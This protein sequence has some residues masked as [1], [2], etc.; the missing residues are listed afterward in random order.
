MKLKFTALEYTAEDA[1]SPAQYSFDGDVTSGWE[2]RRNSQTYLTLGPGYEPMK[3]RLCGVCA[4]DL[5]RRFLPFPL[6]QITGHEVVAVRLHNG[7]KCVVEINDTPHYRGDTV[8]DPFSNAGLPTHTP[9][10]MVL[11]IDRLPGG[12]GPYLLAPKHAVL[13][14]DGIH[15]TAA[16]LVEPFAAALQAVISAPPRHN[17][18]VAILGP[19]RL[20]ALLVAALKA[21]KRAS[22]SAFTICALARRD[23]LLELSRRLGSDEGF[24]LAETPEPSLHHGFDIVY[25]TTGSV[26]GFDLALRLAKRE[27]HLKSTN[28]QKT[29]GLDHLTAFVVDELSLMPFHGPGIERIEENGAWD[30][31]AIYLSPGVKNIDL[32]NKHLFKGDPLSAQKAAGSD[33]FPGRLPRFDV[34]V[35]ATLDEIDSIIRPN[36]ENE[37]ALIRPRGTIFFKGDASGNPLLS[38]LARGGMLRSS[39]CGDF[40]LALQYLQENKEMADDLSH[41][42]VS[43]VFPV[44]E[45]ETAF[46]YAR[47]SESIKVIIKHFFANH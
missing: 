26:S 46:E 11:G 47:R 40:K 16:A 30:N 12:F 34:A 28:G 2:I 14:I 4:T 22:G 23:S 6:P 32:K 42:M 39:R 43:H 5:D 44:S 18:R 15:E 9:G 13:P 7:Q 21:Y 17:D 36:P 10:R 41:Y 35:A 24:N 8:Q 3:N 19:R 29:C 25:D 33:G 37:N 1:F 38:F 27:I 31:Q 45:I 20:G